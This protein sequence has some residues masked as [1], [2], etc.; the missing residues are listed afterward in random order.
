[1]LLVNLVL[2]KKLSSIESFNS[3]YNDFTDNRNEQYPWIL[4]GGHYYDGTGAGIFSF[5]SWHGGGDD[6]FRLILTPSI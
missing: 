1:M 2:Q 3:W 5:I 6:A 4:R